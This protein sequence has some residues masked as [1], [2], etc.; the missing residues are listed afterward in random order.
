M[1]EVVKSFKGRQGRPPIYP[2]KD[3]MDG[4]IHKLVRRED[5]NGD[6]KSFR[7]GAHR[8]AAKEGLKVSTEIVDDGDAI[9]L[10]F[11]TPESD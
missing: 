10:E 3:W 1:S 8:T 2:W 11:Y 9:L 6:A 5:F 7:V 4:Q